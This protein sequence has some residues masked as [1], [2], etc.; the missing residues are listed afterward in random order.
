[1]GGDLLCDLIAEFCDIM[2][3]V[4][5]QMKKLEAPFWVLCHKSDKSRFVQLF[6]VSVFKRDDCGVSRC[7]LQYSEIAD[8][9]A[10]I[11]IADDNALR[12][13]SGKRLQATAIDIINIFAV[14]TFAKNCF[15]CQKQP[16]NGNGA[17]S[18]VHRD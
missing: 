15:A 2:C 1:M 10:L 9:L 3:S 6:Y 7:V 5:E 17:V 12:I 16:G 11:D 13:I 4:A 18:F 8:E 14:V